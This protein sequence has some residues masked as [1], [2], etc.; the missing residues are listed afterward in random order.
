MARKQVLEGEK[1]GVLKR[2][3]GIGNDHSLSVVAKSRTIDLEAASREI[4]DA[5]VRALSEA[6]QLVPNIPSRKRAKLL[7]KISASFG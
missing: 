3:F 1:V 2:A 5:W 4:R 6:V 7:E